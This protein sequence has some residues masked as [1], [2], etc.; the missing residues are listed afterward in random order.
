MFNNS[1]CN[2]NCG[3]DCAARDF[4]TL[5]KA[6]KDLVGELDAIIEYDDHV[7]TTDNDLARRTWQNIRDEELLHVGELLGL[8]TYL[9]PYQISLI[10]KG[11]KEFEERKKREQPRM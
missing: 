8:I 5:Q 6:R 10:E 1:N 2:S 3:G 4:P 7:H 9:A 11:L